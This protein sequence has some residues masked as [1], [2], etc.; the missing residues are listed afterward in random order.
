[1]IEVSY[2]GQQNYWNFI[3]LDIEYDVCLEKNPLEYY[4]KKP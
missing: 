1:M 2:Q 3:L 4:A